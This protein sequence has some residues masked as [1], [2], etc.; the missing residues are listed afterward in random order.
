MVVHAT[1]MQCSPH[2]ELAW[3]QDVFGNVIATASFC[4]P[5]ALL[6]IVSDLAVEQLAAAWP[7]FAVAVEAQSFPFA[8]DDETLV[9][10][11]PFRT[12]HHADP[13]GEVAAW[14]RGFVLGPSTDT[15]SLLKDINSGILDSV[16][17]RLREE[18]G[19]Q[20][21]LETLTLRS[22]S[23]RDIAALLI[24]VVRHLGFG[25]RAV[26][27]YL[28]DPAANDEDVHST[29][30]WAEIFLPGAGWI[31]FDPTHRRMGS[32]NL[33]PVAIGRSNQQVMPVDGGFL[34]PTKASTSMEVEVILAV[35]SQ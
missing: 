9:D 22:G 10:L 24:E 20:S 8:Y 15:L 17:Y 4:E 35:D 21:P 13:A 26:S 14:A 3:T 30:A 33:V 1:S 12:P 23:C 7:V 25:A 5:A 27:G 19:T 18:A 31:A 28:F 2:A 34:G 11:S 32:A 29:H 16:A 6:E